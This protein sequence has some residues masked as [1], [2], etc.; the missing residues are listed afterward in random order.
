MIELVF[1][2]IPKIKKDLSS[3]LEELWN[4][5]N[6]C[7]RNIEKLDI[8]EIN[9]KFSLNYVNALHDK[10]VQLKKQIYKNKVDIAVL[11]Q[12]KYGKSTLLNALIFNDDILPSSGSQ[13]TA[14]I[15]R[16]EYSEDYN[17]KADII[18]FN[19]KEWDDIEKILNCTPSHMITSNPDLERYIKNMT[20]NIAF[21]A[22]NNIN[23]DDFIKSSNF[24]LKID[25]SRIGDYVS[26][27]G[28]KKGKYTPLVKEAIVYSDS[29]ILK[30]C[31]IID[32][33]GTND[34]NIEREKRTKEYLS[35]V[36]ALL[37][38]FSLKR[39]INQQDIELIE[40]DV[41]GSRID[42]VIPLMNHI[43]SIS[44]PVNKIIDDSMRVIKDRKDASP[45]NSFERIIYETIENV[46]ITPVDGLFGLL[47]TNWKKFKDNEK[48]KPFIEKFNI[49]DAETAIE[50][51][52]LIDVIKKIELHILK[53][54][55]IF[56]RLFITPFTS[57]LK[58]HSIFKND[59]HD[60]RAGLVFRREN[61]EESINKIELIIRT[62]TEICHKFNI[63][64]SA[65]EKYSNRIKDEFK[66]MTYI[67][68]D[69]IE[70]KFSSNFD[71]V[72]A[73]IISAPV[74]LKININKK[75]NFLTFEINKFF[76]DIENPAGFYQKL[77]S[78]YNDHFGFSENNNIFFKNRLSSI[79]NDFFN[80][81]E[82]ADKT[83]IEAIISK[84]HHYIFDTVI[85]IQKLKFV[86]MSCN[87][88]EPE[89]SL[90]LGIINTNKN[91]E[92][93]ALQFAEYKKS[94]QS[95]IANHVKEY[96]D[97]EV[98][99]LIDK[100]I[101]IILENA[102]GKFN[103]ELQILKDIAGDNQ[104]IINS[105]H[106]LNEYIFRVDAIIK[107]VDEQKNKLYKV[108]DRIN[109]VKPKLLGE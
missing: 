5:I 85:E 47:G 52:R 45:R 55:S 49:H 88:F 78:L 6:D 27:P 58:I 36:D 93:L 77:S 59:L 94:I 32:T 24:V 26:V 7:I 101:N 15:T 3:H 56:Q 13:E 1:D 21:L 108:L 82:P 79:L 25:I 64:E 97:K 98:F 75:I 74:L 11:A 30:Y 53:D 51:S 2:I 10:I 37:L 19:K 48:F 16:I 29:K 20:D 99:P 68:T 73:S 46:K 35:R 9:E 89:V 62:Y 96:L 42:K 33:P 43:S 31:N 81:I 106:S 41:G 18:F 8:P 70:S 14:V 17:G 102:M 22:S 40:Y 87:C 65:V 95:T 69:Q 100:N 103:R 67:I 90:W 84:I 61:I 34:P 50:L 54:E 4:K 83:I 80:A 109:D 63:L 28:L 39:R 72:C 71:D 107:E 23:K 76:S 57:L 12:V 86:K 60:I 105:T 44:S 66:T 104:K 38:I 91:R 92:S